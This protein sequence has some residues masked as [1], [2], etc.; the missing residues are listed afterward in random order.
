MNGSQPVA[1][2][3]HS[4]NAAQTTESVLLPRQNRFVRTFRRS[5]PAI[6]G[7][8]L[9]GC[10]VGMA[11]FAPQLAPHD[12]NQQ[13]LIDALK[14]P[15]WNASGSWEYLLGTDHLGRDILSRVIFG[16]RISLLVALVSGSIA[17]VL[18]CTMGVLAGYYG[19]RV[20]STIMA[21]VDIQLAFPLILLALALVAVLG[22]SFPNL[23]IVMG[24][25]SWMIYARTI[26]AGVLSIKQREFTLSA[27]AIGAS[28]LRLML[29]HIL[30]NLLPMAVVLFTLEVPRLILVEAGLS[31]LGLG[32]PPSVPTWGRM[33][34][35]GRAYLSVAYWIV[36]FPG[37]ALMWTVL[38]INL[39]GDGLRDALEPRMRID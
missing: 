20:D 18:G 3:A 14:P 31:F 24:L 21:V 26:R 29:R 16:A 8:A 35:D 1:L 32:A 4:Q 9:I 10:V 36:T 11:V 7:L 22:V 33:M 2:S 6:A 34:A 19:G 39:F 17:A 28:D 23:V 25:T 5:V 15:V 27:R 38:G 37:L 30:P 12:P 13:H